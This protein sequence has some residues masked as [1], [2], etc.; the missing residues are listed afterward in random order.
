MPKKIPSKD[1]RQEDRRTAMAQRRVGEG[2]RCACGESRPEALMPGSNPIIC[3]ECQRRKRGH[4]DRDDHHMFGASNSPATINIPTNDHVADL[5]VE[6]RKWPRKTLENPDRSPLLSGA[7][8]IRGFI[9]TVIYLMENF[10]LWIAE[11]LEFLDTFLEQELGRKW[12]KSE[13]ESF[14]RDQSEAD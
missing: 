12:W 3:F 4:S 2:A 5:T 1:P 14:D 8:R 13:L 10:L 9:D 7:A 11:L 6:Q